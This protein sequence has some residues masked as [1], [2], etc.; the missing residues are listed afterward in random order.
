MASKLE[1][2]PVLDGLGQG[3]LIFN[4]KGQLIVDNLA[5]RSILGKDFNLIRSNGWDAVS[6]LFNTQRTN[7]DDMLDAIRDKALESSRPVRFST[8]L[9]GEYLPCWAAAVEGEKGELCI[10]LTLETPDWTAMTDL[11]DKFRLEMK[12]VVE[13]TQGHIDLIMQTIDHH[14]DGAELLGKR[15]SGFTR[16]ITIHMDRVGRLMDMMERLENIRT[17]KLREVIRARRRKIDLENYLED[18]VEELDEIKLIDPETEAHDVRSRLTVDVPAGVAVLASSTYLTHILRDLLRNAIMY[19]IKAT[20][21]KLKV[22]VKNNSVQFDLIDEGYGIRERE[23]ERVF[24][25]FQRAR[26]PQIIAEFGYGLSLYLCKQ[27]VEAMNGRMW[28]ES[29]ENVGT[30][31]SFML[32]LWQDDTSSSSSDSENAS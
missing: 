2:N 9:A 20:P 18:F 7:P 1:L 26:Q 24:V 3:V 11:V 22:Q 29:E 25:A 13:S 19:S 31:M 14:K 21:V 30:T 12:E 23:R 6:T 5:A 8:Y 15:I 27:E 17:G 28:F 16:L 10:M 4:S 32:P